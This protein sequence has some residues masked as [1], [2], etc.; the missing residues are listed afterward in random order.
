ML[1][2]LLLLPIAAWDASGLDVP[3]ARLFGTAQGFFWSQHPAFVWLLHKTPRAIGWVFLLALAWG[4]WQPWGFLRALS[5]AERGEL[6]LSIVLALL[7]V[8]ALKRFSLTSCPW[9]LVEFG[10]TAR[11][12]SHWCWGI[13]DGGAGHCFP[14][15]HASAGFSFVAGWFVLRRKLPLVALRWLW[16]AL[17]AG[18]V[19]G[20]VQQI[21]GAHYVSH[22]LWTAWICWFVGWGVE[23]SK[24]IWRYVLLKTS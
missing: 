20:L 23:N 15:G 13:T 24:C 1:T 12:V 3:A 17:A 9:D 5:K 19:L 2:L 8:V 11:Y 16:A 7:A 18:C 4:V 21:R 14:A 22:T 10:G 6:L